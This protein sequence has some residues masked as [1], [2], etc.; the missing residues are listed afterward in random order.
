[1]RA[2]RAAIV[3]LGLALAGCRGY[4]AAPSP[5]SCGEAGARI[6][7]SMREL[8]PV[9]AEAKLDATAELTVMCKEDRWSPTV[10]AC[11]ARAR[12]AQDHRRCAQDLDLGQREHARVIQSDLYERAATIARDQRRAKGGTGV[13]ACDAYADAIEQMLACPN[14]PKDTV[15]QMHQGL[16]AMRSAWSRIDLGDPSAIDAALESCRIQADAVQQM[17]KSFGC[18]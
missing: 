16:D 13:P 5:P 1:M 6:A 8:R 12:I 17:T 4:A 11:F 7:A 9:L 3:G 15:V 2:A 14:I 18:P 10:V